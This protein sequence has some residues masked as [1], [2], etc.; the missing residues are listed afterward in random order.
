MPHCESLILG[1]FSFLQHYFSVFPKKRPKYSKMWSVQ[2]RK[3]LKRK[4]MIMSLVTL[5]FIFMELNVES[6]FF[7]RKNSWYGVGFKCDDEKLI[8]GEVIFRN[9]REKRKPCKN[10][11]VIIPE[12]MYNFEKGIKVAVKRLGEVHDE[13]GKIIG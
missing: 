9:K 5:I 1:V 2:W 7:E 12:G 4:K 13:K 6:F 8:Y 10:Y 11:Y 3:N